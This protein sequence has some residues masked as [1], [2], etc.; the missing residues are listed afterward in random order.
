MTNDG[1]IGVYKLTNT[2]DAGYMP[3]MQLVKQF[4]A[5]FSRQRVGINR[6][7]AALGVNAQVDAVF[8]LWNTHIGTA[9]PKDLYAVF[10]PS[11]GT[12]A[13]DEE[14]FRI[15]LAQEVVEQ[16]AVD[17][18]VERLDSFY[19]IAEQADGSG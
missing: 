19:D 16:D 4:D 7:Y 6:L 14:K 13:G 10:S 18:T 9:M 15:T 2:A 11:N 8:R 5:Y 17:I 1:I 3:V 12:V